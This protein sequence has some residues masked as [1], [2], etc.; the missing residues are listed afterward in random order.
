MK[1]LDD[2][3]NSKVVMFKLDQSARLRMNCERHHLQNYLD[4][5]LRTKILA[6]SRKMIYIDTYLSNISEYSLS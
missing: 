1:V 2:S 4:L 6:H 3:H 5:S